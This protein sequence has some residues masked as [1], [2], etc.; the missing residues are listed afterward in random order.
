MPEID[1]HRPP[2]RGGAPN[3]ATPDPAAPDL[4]TPDLATP[5]VA[6]PDPEALS[7]AFPEP[8]P[9]A[10]AS[11][12]WAGA[13]GKPGAPKPPTGSGPVLRAAAILLAGGLLLSLMGALVKLL[14]G[15]Y[16]ASELSAWR[17]LLGLIPAFAILW[18]SSEWKA[19]GRPFRLKRWKLALL[20]GVFVALAQLC[21]YL[22][23]SRMEFATAA[24]LVFAGPLFVTALSGGLLGAPVGAWRWGAVIAGFVGVA[25]IL[26]PG[27]EAFQVWSLAPLGAALGYAASS[28]CAPLIDRDAPTPLVNLYSSSAAMV[29]AFGLAMAT[30]G[31]TAI[32]SW[33]DMGLI[34]AI[35]LCGGLG[36]ICLVGAYR[37]ASPPA[38]APFEY[39]GMIYALALGWLIFGESPVD[40]LFPGAPLIVAAGLTIAWRE[41]RR[42][43]A[44]A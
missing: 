21:Y 31:F 33:Q 1:P 10:T 37:L 6:A 22:A 16:G 18:S 35:G 8:A 29:G 32:G 19:R 9:A 14:L 39:F 44:R 23:L 4:A 41:R 30:G 13:G 20:R 12:A 2:E 43:P 36:V 24:T 15:R 5:D 27:A 38:L 7:A 26:Q 3:P 28:V 40:K 11:R 34:L 17:N 42:R 25:L